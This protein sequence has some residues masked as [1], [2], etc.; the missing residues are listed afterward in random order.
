MKLDCFQQVLLEQ[1]LADYEDLPEEAP[2]APP[3]QAAAIFRRAR[4]RWQP[5]STGVRVAGWAS[6][7][8]I[9]ALVLGLWSLRDRHGPPPVTEP[10]HQTTA[11]TEPTV[12]EP[13]ITDPSVTEPT[14]PSE[15]T[16][17]TL[18]VM[19]YAADQQSGWLDQQLDAFEEDHPDYLITWDLSVRDG[20]DDMTMALREDP[21]PDADIYFIRANDL[22]LV[23]GEGLISPIGEDAQRLLSDQVPQAAWDTVRFK[24][25][26]TYGLPLSCAFAPVLVYRKSV[27]STQDIGSLETLLDKGTVCFPLTTAYYGTMFFH[28]NG[29]SVGGP[30]IYEP[31]YGVRFGGPEGHEVG[32]KLSEVSAHPNLRPYAY[33]QDFLD[34]SVDAFIDNAVLYQDAR[35]VFGDDVGI[36]PMPTIT[37]S[38]RPMPLKTTLD[39]YMVCVGRRKEYAA[40][41]E[42]LAA[43][44]T[45]PEAQAARHARTGAI[46]IAHC[47]METPAVAADPL[48]STIMIEAFQNS[49][50]YRE[51]EDVAPGFYSRM[52]HLLTSISAEKPTDK[53][54][55]Y[56]VDQYFP[57]PV[58]RPEP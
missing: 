2:S 41:T 49:V 7:L 17:V 29:G 3:R 28:A 1:V 55:A 36:A 30:G 37:L 39:F 15:P 22:D 32:R 12:T 8:L 48:A 53:R 35:P 20:W 57:D 51:P 45:S 50:P 18:K 14:A 10:T 16:P 25:G 4:R 43:H 21:E 56:F 23:M 26:Y 34:G 33:P 38:G 54:A 5:V 46:P 47:L 13:T 52:T 58:I 6:I 27:L 31:K 40:L 42:Q 9:P 24:G 44:L 11:P 19:A